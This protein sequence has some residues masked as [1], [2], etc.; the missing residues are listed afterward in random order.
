MRQVVF[1][2]TRRGSGDCFVARGAGITASS[3]SS[4][5]G[6]AERVALK[7]KLGRKDVCGL[8]IEDHGIVLEPITEGEFGVGQYKASWE[9][10]E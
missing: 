2:F 3:T 8:S 4:P 6:A 5:Q 10:S 7:I 9:E 1:I